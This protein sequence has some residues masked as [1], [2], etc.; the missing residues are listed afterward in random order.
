MK[1]HHLRD[2]AAI[3]NSHSVRG[4]AR[5]LNLAQPAL[6]RSLRELEAELGVALLE[7]HARG[8][9]LTPIGHAFLAH[10][11]SAMQEIRRG[12]ER[13]AQM[14]G[15]Q[16][17]SVCVGLSSAAWLTLVPQVYTPFRKKF[18]GVRLKMMEG[19]FSILESRLQDG[20]MD[21]YVGPRPE[22]TPADSFQVTLL[23]QNERLVVC[24]RDHPLRQATRLD[25]LVGSEWI[26]TGLREKV[27][28]E[29][30]EIFTSHDLTPPNPM[31]H[32]ES[33]VGV[34]VLLTATNA[35]A[36]LPRQWADSE[37]FTSVVQPV[38]LE[39]KLGG[40]DIVQ[41]CRAGLPLTP[42][43]DYFSTLIARAA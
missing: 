15:E 32:A 12:Q 24:R 28:T 35:F 7:R 34:A 21:F 16:T 42:A 2:F 3:A 6:T 36:V 29:F 23:F 39:E 5:D 20:T 17:G 27:E 33:M 18:P 43:A 8:V 10:A 11:Q 14:R 40:P 22:R 37:V 25:Q 13:V 19:A 41:I 9:V 38:P 26:L 1:L 31:T 30:E 4:A